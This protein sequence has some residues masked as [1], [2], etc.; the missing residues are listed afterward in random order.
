M[1]IASWSNLLAGPTG[2]E[3][4]IS[5]VTGERICQLFYDPESGDKERKDVV[6]VLYQL[7]YSHP[8]RGVG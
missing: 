4:A 2:L 6:R 3:P 5:P 7:S 1:P 8:V